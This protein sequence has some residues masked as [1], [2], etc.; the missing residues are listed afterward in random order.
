MALRGERFL[1]AD[2]PGAK[3][4]IS[5]DLKLERSAERTL[6]TGRVRLPSADIN[7]QRLP[8][9]N[10]APTASDDVVIVDDAADMARRAQSAPL[11]A[12]ITIE[13]GDQ[14]KLTGYGL[15]ATVAG[16]LEVRERPGEPTTG[17]GEIRVA[18]TYKAYGQDLTIRQG[19]LLY[20]ATPLDNPNLSITAVRVVDVITA[21]FRV[22]GT[23]QSPQLAVFS[24]PSMGQSQALAYIVTGKSLDEIGQGSGSESDALRSAAQSLGSAAGGLLA[25]NLGKRL[26]VDEVGVKESAALGGSALTVGQY[27][28]PAPVSQLRR[29]PLHAGRGD[30]A[31]LQAHRRAVARSGKRGA[32]LA[33][34]PALQDRA[35]KPPHAAP[36][37]RVRRA[38]VHEAT[39]AAERR[40][41][42]ERLVAGG[43][44]RRREG[45]RILVEDVVR[46]PPPR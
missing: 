31:A 10:R 12:S 8:R 14:V 27:L 16:Q 26:G 44:D 1:A 21:G 39:G 7:L 4:V 22:T 43:V 11:Q 35:L 37:E 29:G 34:G 41:V 2:I 30:H 5:P 3:V 19:Q 24:D 23:A 40:I 36:L 38:A 18:G 42:R 9:G 15:D 17:A 25:K 33:R 13:L 28:S 20:A 46:P 6:L 32:E 45:P